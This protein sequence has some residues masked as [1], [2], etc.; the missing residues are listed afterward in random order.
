MA[1]LIVKAYVDPGLILQM[2]YYITVNGFKNLIFSNLKA[3]VKSLYIGV[4]N[5][6]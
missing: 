4:H 1:A 3:S 2:D 5:T 6:Y